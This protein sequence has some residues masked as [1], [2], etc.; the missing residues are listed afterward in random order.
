MLRLIM[1]VLLGMML[2]AGSAEMPELPVKSHI[3]MDAHSGQI[4]A[5]KDAEQRLPP[6]NITKLMTKSEN[7][8]KKHQDKDRKSFGSKNKDKKPQ[9]FDRKRTRANNKNENQVK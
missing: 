2:R 5:A 7:D 3:L 8:R 6:A 4:L 1:A 9:M